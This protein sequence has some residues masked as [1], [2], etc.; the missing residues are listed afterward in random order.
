MELRYYSFKE[1]KKLPEYQREQLRLWRSKTSNKNAD[2]GDG[3]VPPKKQS[4]DSRISSLE[5]QNE[6]LNGKIT[7]LLT[8]VSDQG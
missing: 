4:N 3:G 5:T 6:D 2:Q 7:Q 1:Y 8:T